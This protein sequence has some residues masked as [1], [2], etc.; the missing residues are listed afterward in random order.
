MLRREL[1]ARFLLAIR[2]DRIAEA[3][4]LIK[5]F[6]DSGEVSSAALLVR[7]D[8]FELLRGYGKASA[9]TP[10]LLA[11]ITKPMTAGGLMVLRDRGEFKL[12]DPVRRF[13][14][15]FTGGDRD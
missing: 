6:I 8:R 9:K 13:V 7:Q 1:L 4:A 10:F 14:P 12:D 5:K 2:R 11:S 15:Q 3:E